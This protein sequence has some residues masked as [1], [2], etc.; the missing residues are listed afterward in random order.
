VALRLKSCI[1]PRLTYT[2]RQDWT[3]EGV[4]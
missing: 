4:L 2:Y 1:N 3:F